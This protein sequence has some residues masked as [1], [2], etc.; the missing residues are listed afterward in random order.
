MRHAAVLVATV[1]L[2]VPCAARAE[3]PPPEPP[4]P[5]PP[6]VSIDSTRPFTVVERRANHVTGWSLTVPF[7]AYVVTEQWEPVC[8]APCELR[9][10]P[11]AVYR[12]GGGGVAPSGNFPIPRGA[13]SL[14]LH[15]HAGSAFWHSA[16]IV[17]TILG[18][19]SV[20]AGLAF[21]GG[22]TVETNPE[23]A[24]REGFAFIV[25]GVVALVT[26]AALWIFC[27]SSVTGDDGRTL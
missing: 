8:V 14:R 2:L 22:A 1:S 4:P 16:G 24:L 3:E 17:T 26:G 9:L 5:L 20:T 10:D 21:T 27:G 13:D 11:N 25:P 23:L 18:A 15:V 6:L 7:P 19:A 12:V